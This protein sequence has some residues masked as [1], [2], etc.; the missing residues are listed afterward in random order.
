MGLYLQKDEVSYNGV[1]MV[2]NKAKVLLN[3]CSREEVTLQR[4][5]QLSLFSSDSGPMALIDRKYVCR[6][7]ND[8]YLKVIGKSRNE[9]EGCRVADIWA[10]NPYGDVTL[11]NME[12]AFAGEALKNEIWLERGEGVKLF[13][14]V[15]Y[16]PLSDDEG[17]NAVILITRDQTDLKI[18]ENELKKSQKRYLNIYN[19]APIAF[20]TW[21]RDFRV[22]GWNKRAE[23][24]FGW[25]SEEV[26][27]R[28]FFSF[29]LPESE[30]M[31][32]DLKIIANR[33]LEGEEHID[34]MHNNLTRSGKQIT[35]EWNNSP[36]YNSDDEIIGGLSLGADVTDRVQAE[37]ELRREKKISDNI[38]NSLPGIFSM[39]DEFG[40]H[41][42]GNG[43]LQDVTGYSDQDSSGKL[44][45]DFVREDQREKTADLFN[46]LMN[47]DVPPK[48]AEITLLAKDGKQI[49]YQFYASRIEMDD[50]RYSIAL[51]MD[52][53]AQK[54]QE[55]QLRES[56]NQLRLLMDQSPL[57]IEIYDADGLL[58][59]VNKTFEKLWD[60]SKEAGL[61][62]F[63]ILKSTYLAEIGMFDYIKRAYNG[64]TIKTPAYEFDPK[65]EVGLL[66][67]GRPRWVKTFLYPLHDE[68][69]EVKNLVVIHED[70]TEIRQAGEEQKRL[71]RQLTE[72]QKMKA[73][74]T[75]AGGIAHDF[76]NILGVIMGQAE[77]IELFDTDESSPVRPRLNEILKASERARNLVHQI[78]TISRHSKGTD[79][80]VDLVPL[81]KEV[82]KFIRASSPATIEIIESIDSEKLVVLS[83]PSKIHQVFLN[84]CTNAVQAMGD[85]NGR[86]EVSLES[87][88]LDEKSV[89]Q[90]AHLSVGMYV[91][92]VISDTGPGMTPEI[93]EKIFEPY[94][95]TKNEG[96]GTGL[97]LAVVHGIV[98]QQNGHIG[99]YSEEGNGTTFRILLPLI[100]ADGVVV[101]EEVM[102]IKGGN[103]SIMIVDDNEPLLQTGANILTNLGY[104]VTACSDS[105][106]ALNIFSIDPSYYDLVLTDLS[107]PNLTGVGLYRELSAIRP[108][109]PVIICSGFGKTMSEE[110]A[111]KTGF[112]AFL[113]K[114]LETRLLA[115]TIRSIFDEK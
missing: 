20:V 41:I 62:I 100:D 4:Y 25:S 93:R 86:L 17:V 18:A 35:V 83:D 91:M 81:V 77:L 104:Q 110:T 12:R 10:G 69:G 87:V 44:R 2:E 3:S 34:T 88:E 45:F 36:L 96:E 8:A 49:P 102:P 28:N 19:N 46:K 24:T 33:I 56:K 9:V 70:I 6:A 67:R 23:K 11:S 58:V 31:K 79:V 72:A 7:V 92:I 22:T 103:E 26:L 84:L 21:D 59:D 53:S 98:K 90:Y 32:I 82:S 61:N 52:I 66:G 57:S 55:Q 65:Y 47:D 42:R 109:I 14:E 5:K 115:G 89:Q 51:G 107:M 50:V 1:N 43:R 114:P 101:E 27:G 78:L 40:N 48:G 16:F 68:F 63:N 112:K 39:F 30:V 76:N 99:V 74:G 108:D 97:G 106:E 37:N 54:K 13:L 111:Q 85:S 64:E 75:L 73:I 94:F 105:M 38:I 80:P 29:L 113:E 15:N 71:E 60:I 95:T